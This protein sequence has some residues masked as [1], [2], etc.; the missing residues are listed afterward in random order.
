[1]KPFQIFRAGKHI[2]A[3]GRSIEFSEDD[4]RAAVAAYDPAVH[5][6]P[7][8]VGHPVDN[9]PA[10]GWIKSISFDEGAIVAEPIQLDEAFSE[11]VVSG[12]FKKRSAS[13]YTPDAPNN[14]KPGA[15]YLRHV[16]FLGAQPPAVKGLREVAFGE[17]EDGVVEFADSQWIASLMGSMARRMRDFFIG[18][19]GVEKADSVLPDYLVADLEAEG[20]KTAA[21]VPGPMF[22][23]PK[24]EEGSADMSITKDQLDAEVAAKDAALAK[25]AAAEAEVATLKAQVASFA[26]REAVLARA[27][28]DAAIAKLVTEG[29]ILPAAQKATA[30]FAMSLADADATFDFGEG[31]EAKKLTQRGV[32]LANLAAGPVVVNYNE[33]SGSNKGKGAA[34]GVTAKAISDKAQKLVADQKAAGKFL[35]FTDAVAQVEAE[36]TA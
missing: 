31:A 9:G 8:V 12:R 32:Y 14:P 6:A 25:Q 23:E 35:S 19:W 17:A 30:D 21:D 2:A 18:E 29:R 11:M 10:Y 27:G 22:N 7:I 26:E 13:F 16:G 34:E 24:T 33:L 3:S 1:M 36:F 4:L 15:Y 5:E 20:R 28:V